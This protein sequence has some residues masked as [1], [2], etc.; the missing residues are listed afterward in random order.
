LTGWAK[1]ETWDNWFLHHVFNLWDAIPIRRGEVDM[2]ALRRALAVLKDGYVFVIAPEG[3]RN[4]TGR[5]RRAL[6][7]A[8]IIALHSGVPIM[9]LAH[10]GGE[11]ILDNLKR[12][13]RTDFHVRVGEPLRIN[14]NGAK[15]NGKMRQEIVDEMMYRLAE[16]MPEEY[17]GEYSDAGRATGKYLERV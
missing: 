13:K 11:D 8:V 14:T 10:W 5:L 3:T 15:V 12:L 6:P 16:L 4:K 2:S 9:P 7:G 1:I 17:R